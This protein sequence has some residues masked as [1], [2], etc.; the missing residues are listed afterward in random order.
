[1]R[2][3]RGR[4]PRSPPWPPRPDTRPAAREAARKA[5]RAGSRGSRSTG[6]RG[7]PSAVLDRRGPSCPYVAMPKAAERVP[8]TAWDLG[9]RRQGP[10][11][12][13]RTR[14]SPR[15][16]R[17]PR[18]QV[19]PARPCAIAG[20]G[21]IGRRQSR[22]SQPLAVERDPA[23]G[24]PRGLLAAGPVVLGERR[25]GPFDRR[26]PA[27]DLAAR[28]RSLALGQ[29]TDRTARWSKPPASRARAG[30]GA[31][32]PRPP[33]PVRRGRGADRGLERP[34]RSFSGSSRRR[35]D[36]SPAIVVAGP[37]PPRRGDRRQPDRGGARSS[38]YPQGARLR[39]AAH[40]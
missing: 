24:D 3:E 11:R 19:M 14:P 38:G 23:E 40:H 39:R 29:V 6:S 27:T 15:P 10:R 21:R 7:P 35:A 12:P 34:K 33:R 4:A 28:C 5:D 9:R 25:S 13:E 8:P 20:A 16:S 18:M 30:R 26:R 31:R 22:P 2:D 1:M 37:D 17:P 36:R 32:R